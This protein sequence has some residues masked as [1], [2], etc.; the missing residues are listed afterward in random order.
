MQCN[1]ILGRA[2][3]VCVATDELQVKA[4]KNPRA[5]VGAR[6]RGHDV[7]KSRF[8]G[9]VVGLDDAA[10]MTLRR[11]GFVVGLVGVIDAA[12]AA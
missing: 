2:L 8:F 3:G 12:H 10:G 1:V 5:A 6:L 7:E 4:R 9:L 11:G